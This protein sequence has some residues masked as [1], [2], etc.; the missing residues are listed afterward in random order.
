MPVFM[1]PQF[2]WSFD[3]HTMQNSD[4]QY[5]QIICGQPDIRSTKAEQSGHTAN[6]I[7]L[8]PS[9]K[10]R[11]NISTCSSSSMPHAVFPF[12]LK[13][14]QDTPEWNFTSQVMHCLS[15]HFSLGQTTMLPPS[16]SRYSPQF[17]LMQNIPLSLLPE[18]AILMLRLT[19]LAVCFSVER[20]CSTC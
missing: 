18:K 5:A 2:L 20:P 14:S 7:C 19:Y 17:S 8:P 11:F 3:L 16:E 9:L 4:L 10:S 13:S 6:A 1:C 15:A 12:F